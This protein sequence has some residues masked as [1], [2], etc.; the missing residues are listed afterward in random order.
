MPKRRTAERSS[1]RI[2]PRRFSMSCDVDAGGLPGCVG[3]AAGHVWP[4]SHTTR[5][6]DV[7]MTN[8][9]RRTAVAHGLTACPLPPAETKNG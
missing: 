6:A 5:A 1:L 2:D 8:S 4:N 7:D 3:L 9:D